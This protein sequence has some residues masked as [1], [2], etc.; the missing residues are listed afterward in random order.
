ML[1]LVYFLLPYSEVCDVPII[2]N[3]DN[4]KT[5]QKVIQQVHYELA[6]LFSGTPRVVF[7][8]AARRVEVEA[9][10][11]AWPEAVGVLVDS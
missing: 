5:I 3:Y 9:G 1:S 8:D 2:T 6:L 10:T 11:Q 4:E 7:G